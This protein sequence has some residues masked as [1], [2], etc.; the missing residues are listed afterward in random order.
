M[1]YNSNLQNKNLKLQNILNRI[2]NLPTAGSTGGGTDTSDATA[3][4]E[5]VYQGETFYSANGKETGT[6]SLDTEI[7]SQNELLT[8]IEAALATKAS[9]NYE[10]G[11][12]AGKQELYDA[13]W[14]MY[15]QNGTLKDY[16]RAFARGRFTDSLFKP[17]YDLVPDEAVCM[18]M[19]AELTNLTQLLKDAGVVLDTSQARY[20]SQ[21][22]QYS[23]ITHIP[24][25]DATAVTNGLSS[26]FQLSR[27]LVEIEKIIVKESLTFSNAFTFLDALEEIRFEGVIASDIDFKHS[28][29]LSKAS[30][31]N[32]ISCMST[33]VSGK[34]LT[35][36][37]D[38]VNKAFETSTG[39]NNGSSSTEWNL[40]INGDGTAANPGRTNWTITL[41]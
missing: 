8:Q 41:V 31:Q 30:I 28:S 6:M 4:P 37:K 26:T 23:T 2:N 21:M 22:F 13:F 3:T 7:A 25:I 34:T 14:D 20:L 12:A 27:Q 35:L 38:A 19:Y 18:F 32:I 29:K 40:L 15:Q 36:K 39:A 1:S 17:K 16:N 11:V 9:G 5:L 10:T 24:T 33:T